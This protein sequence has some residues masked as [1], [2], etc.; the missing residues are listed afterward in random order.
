M[1]E[2]R[3]TRAEHGNRRT[4]AAGDTANHG[5]QRIARGHQRLGF[6]GSFV[7]DV[8]GA[9]AEIGEGRSTHAGI[10]L[11]ARLCR[12]ESRLVGRE[13]AATILASTRAAR[14]RRARRVVRRPA[15]AAHTI[16]FTDLPIVDAASDEE[17]REPMKSDGS[18][19][20]QG[21]GDDDTS[22]DRW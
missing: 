17:R 20:V 7:R 3:R 11:L 6:G 1:L 18:T 19:D 21:D 2:V 22:T 14:L 5:I 15:D 16:F 10:G 12:T 8:R 9:S 4:R 13:L